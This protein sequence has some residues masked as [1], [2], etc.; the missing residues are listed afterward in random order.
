MNAGARPGL[1]AEELGALLDLATDALLV[2]ECDGGRILLANSGCRSLLGIGS[3]PT[4][5]VTLASVARKSRYS[6]E[7]V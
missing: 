1:A 2:A 5:T 4:E 7:A 6:H 3:D